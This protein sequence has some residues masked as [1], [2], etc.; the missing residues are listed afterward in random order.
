MQDEAICDSITLSETFATLGSGHFVDAISGDNR[1]RS[2]MSIIITMIGLP[3][4]SAM[5]KKLNS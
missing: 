4:Y 3:V 2:I 1:L 5:S